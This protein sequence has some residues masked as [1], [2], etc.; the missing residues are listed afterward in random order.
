MKLL[1]ILIF[2]SLNL[3]AID[4]NKDIKPIL[5]RKCYSCHGPKKQKGKLRLDQRKDALK[6]LSSKKGTAEFLVRINH[7]DPEEIMPPPEDGALT[8]KEK[9]LLKLWV[10]EGAAYEAHWSFQIV[11]NPPSPDIQNSW[12]SNDIDKFIFKKLTSLNLAPQP[13]KFDH[14]L[15][16]RVS[17]KLTGLPPSQEDLKLLNQGELNYKDYVNRLLASPAYGEHMATF[18]LD[19]ARYADTNGIE[20]DNSRPIWPYRDWVINA[21]NQNMPYDQFIT[22]QV[23]GDLLPNSKLS[24]KIATGFLRCNVTTNEAG[25]IEEEFQVRYAKDRLSTTMTAITGLTAACAECH[26]HKYDPISQKEYYQLLAYFNNLEGKAVGQAN[27]PANDPV[28]LTDSK[29]FQKLNKLNDEKVLLEKQLSNIRNK[30][31]SHFN[32]WHNANLTSPSK[33]LYLLNDFELYFSFDET[34]NDDIIN[35]IDDKA[36]LFRG[37]LNK[38][39]GR[40]EEGIKCT[41]AFYVDCPKT[42]VYDQDSTFSAGFWARPDHEDSSGEVLGQFYD[43]KGWKIEINDGFVDFTLANSK[44]S[45]LIVRATQKLPLDTWNHVVVTYDGSGSASGV[46]FYINNKENSSEVRQ[47]SLKGSTRLN[48][49]LRVAVFLENVT[50]DDVFITKKILSEDQ[51]PIISN[52]HAASRL[53]HYKLQDLSD[54]NLKRLENY[55]FGNQHLES[56]KQFETFQKVQNELFLLKKYSDQSLV[57]VEKDKPKVTHILL[58][59]DYQRKGAKVNRQ[60]PEFLPAM[61]VNS[62]NN[63]LGLAKWLTDKKHPLTSR[64]LVNRIWLKIFNRGLFSTPDDIGIQGAYPSH[65]E[66]LDYLSTYLM[67]SNWN[68]KKLVRLIINSSTF[69]Q[70]SLSGNKFHSYNSFPKHRLSAE[71]IRDQLLILSE[72]INKKIGGKPVFPYQPP[73][74]W[75]ES[76]ADGSNTKIFKQ[77]KGNDNYRRSIYSFWKRSLPPPSMSIFDAPNRQTCS[78][79]RQETNTP[80]QA[81]S[82]MNDPQFIELY[83]AIIKRTM[84][85]GSNVEKINFLFKTLYFR[86]PKPKEF[87][88]IQGLESNKDLAIFIHALLNTDEFISIK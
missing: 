61:N 30:S 83:E 50:I 11:R 18:W 73:G 70:Q 78:M 32:N 16:K 48:A 84:E 17:F 36:G 46:K 51:I 58:K 25:S 85:K 86:I 82:L 26:D 31:L 65:P 14:N 2:F 81:L 38:V 34:E 43:V 45:A 6:V 37:P 29:K 54:R 62:P 80:L 21:F 88:L 49:I 23:A 57:A 15:L 33:A 55:Y 24:Q 41:G 28:I 56:T 47:S 22:E 13:V 39:D 75:F 1:L 67:E 53:V 72:K 7:N 27:K 63:R 71:E 52:F 76:T 87:I 8:D 59:G 9:S 35:I 10:N 69:K 44:E 79:S 68:I 40:H 4:F 74:L 60:T 19:G 64:V 3:T 77:S 5:A 12:I 66:L 42:S 20:Y